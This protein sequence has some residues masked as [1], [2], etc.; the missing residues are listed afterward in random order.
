[1]PGDVLTV[2]YE[3]S[4]KPEIVITNWDSQKG[5]Y[6][7]NNQGSTQVTA[8]VSMVKGIIQNIRPNPAE[9]IILVEFYAPIKEQFEVSIR[10]VTGKVIFTKVYRNPK[11]TSSSIDISSFSDGTYFLEIK[12]A[13]HADRKK[14]VIL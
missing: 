3:Y 2:L 4:E 14:F 11:L 9:N 10:D 1:M 7:F 5:N 13:K 6:I 8:P 12:T